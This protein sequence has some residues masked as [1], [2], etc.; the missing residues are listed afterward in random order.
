V[1]DHLHYAVVLLEDNIIASQICQAECQLSTKTR[2]YK[3][4]TKKNSPSPERGS[5]PER[6]GK[7]HGKFDPF[8]RRNKSACTFRKET[9]SGRTQIV[10]CGLLALAAIGCDDE[11]A[12]STT[13]VETA[14]D[15]WC[16]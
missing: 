7:I 9:V 12:P 8:K 6:S 14:D 16:G 15:L 1:K 10:G 2:V 11:V 13:L 4:C 5:A 3:T